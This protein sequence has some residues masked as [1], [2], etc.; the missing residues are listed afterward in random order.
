MDNTI[1]IIRGDDQALDLTIK[2]ADA[3]AFDLTD[4]TVYFTVKKRFHDTDL[5]A[6]IK[7]DVTIHSNP[8]GGLTTVELT[9]EDTTIDARKYLWDI[10]VKDASDKIFSVVSGD[11]IVKHDVTNRTT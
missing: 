8:T 7:K 5:E 3:T 11:F 6:V 4:C 1:T 9:A 10:Q 2:N